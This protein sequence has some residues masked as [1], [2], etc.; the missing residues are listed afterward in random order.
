M[1]NHASWDYTLSMDQENAK[2]L[3]TTLIERYEKAKAAD[4][5]GRYTEEETKKGFIEPLFS[6]LG[7]EIFNRRQVTAEEKIS[8]DRVDYGFY[9]NGRI[10]FY[11]EAKPLRADIHKEEYAEQAI[12]YAWNK[13]VAWAVLTDFERLKVFN[14]LSPEKSLAGKLYFDIPYTEYLSR[15]DQLWQLSKESFQSDLI[16]AEARKVGKMLQK[17]SVSDQLSKDLNLCREILNKTFRVWNEQLTAEEIDEGVQK[18][19]DRL[20]FLRVA[21]DRKIEPPTLR[22]L[23][24]QW[25]AGGRRGSPYQVMIKKF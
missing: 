24:N 12:R 15:F 6:A 14:A 2:Q 13:G 25:I 3:I 7:W 19:L 9:L 5:I 23:I 21:E 8:G 4:E 20:V 17:V 10:K 22:P 1:Q 11:L 16:E 18:L